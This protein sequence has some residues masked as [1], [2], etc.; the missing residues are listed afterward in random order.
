MD[1]LLADRLKSYTLGNS[2]Y[3][4]ESFHSEMFL[5]GGF[6]EFFEK[7]YGNNNH[8]LNDLSHGITNHRIKKM[9]VFEYSIENPHNLRKNDLLHT[10]KNLNLINVFN[11]YDKHKFKSG[12]DIIFHQWL[13]E[14]EK[15]GIDISEEKLRFLEIQKKGLECLNKV[16]QHK[17]V[18]DTAI[19]KTSE[20]D[21]SFSTVANDQLKIEKL[22]KYYEENIN[23][24]TVA[25]LCNLASSGGYGVLD[26]KN[27]FNDITASVLQKIRQKQPHAYCSLAETYSQFLKNGTGELT[28]FF[29]TKLDSALEHNVE[30]SKSQSIK[31]AALFVDGSILFVDKNDQH[32]IPANSREL[33]ERIKN[34]YLD[35]IDFKFR[36]QPSFGK[37]F[38][39][40]LMEDFE[41]INAALSTANSFLINY[42]ILKQIK[43]DKSILDKS[44]ESIN[45]FIENS[46]KTYKVYRFANSILSSKNKHLMT[47]TA[48]PY[49]E[50]FYDAKLKEEFVQD[51]IGKK[52]AMLNTP[53]EFTA[54]VKDV[55]DKLFDFGKYATM[56]LLNSI[57]KETL[58]HTTE[59]CIVHIETF[60]ES[61]K[62]G[63]NNW[64]ISRER[65]Y[66][67]DY[68]RSDRRQYFFFD[69]TKE[70]SDTMSMIGIT[71]REDGQIYAA[72]K[73]NDDS[74]K[75][76]SSMD[77]LRIKI[78]CAE[79]EY[80]KE[81]LYGDLKNDVEAELKSRERKQTRTL[82]NNSI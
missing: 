74:V 21:T 3:S 82:K 5:L 36:K 65:S 18:I 51:Y 52:L 19:Y 62:L 63:T 23:Y 42:D 1:I 7:N 6:E 46:T 29:A 22:L 40:K 59:E 48:Y 73:K 12:T 78:I 75:N 57:N 49:F 79:Y 27:D 45:D 34:F 71:L 20:L 81:N 64:C 26:L 28:S 17:R 11:S 66:F 44:F 58:I 80:Y 4:L 2:I 43:F 25:S 8:A 61:K 13:L 54:F 72:H 14:A 55:H 33:N 24:L 9:N 38:K 60:E 35:L 39:T 77:D 76:H 69:Y 30:L 50:K 47:E 16:N 68:A 56:A 31:R 37:M 32:I 70:S 41:D 53:E 10:T 67:D 15:H